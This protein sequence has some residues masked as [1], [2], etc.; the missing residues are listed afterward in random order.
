LFLALNPP[1]KAL[2]SEASFPLFRSFAHSTESIT[3]GTVRHARPDRTS[4]GESVITQ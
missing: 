3:Q 1:S 4:T 2:S